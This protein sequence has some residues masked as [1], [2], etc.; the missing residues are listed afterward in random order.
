[1]EIVPL[2]NTGFSYQDVLNLI[3]SAFQ[4]WEELGIES[5]LLSLTLEQFIE[6]T[7]DSMV[8]IAIED[9]NLVGTTTC[10][11]LKDKYNIVY[12]F[13]KYS[14]VLNMKKKSGVGTLLLN[15]EKQFV[16]EN[17][18]EY[19]IS[20]TSVLATWSIKWHKKN[21][22]RIIGYKSFSNNRYYSYVF[23][24]QLTSP[25]IWNN[26]LFTQLVY[27]CSMLKTKAVKKSDGSL[28]ALGRLIMSYIC[29][30][31]KIIDLR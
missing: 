28:T 21:N 13:N 22:F 2:E 14:A 6:R 18:C 25:S 1:M 27:R 16:K 8:F 12:A 5:S 17:G 3:H 24:C 23:R 4:Q 7:K 19:I 9:G 26:V 20:D 31:N 11:I 15:A 30:I 10:S 29:A